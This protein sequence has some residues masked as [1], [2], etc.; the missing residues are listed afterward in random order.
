MPRVYVGTFLTGSEAV[1]L[2][3][4]S[5][6]L[7]QSLDI[8]GT[9]ARATPPEKLHITWQ[10]LGDLEIDKVRAV[11]DLLVNL[12]P[13]IRR[14][15]AP[16]VVIE[17]NKLALWPTADAARVLVVTPDMVRQE[18][19]QTATFVR[20][21]LGPYLNVDKTVERNFKFMPHLTIMRFKEPVNADLPGLSES[22]REIAPV[23]QKIDSIHL[24]ESHVGNNH[25]YESLLA[26]DL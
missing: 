11:K 22:F 19:S 13:E 18:L 4:Y 24:I 15:A 14:L 17:Y 10:F 6:T 7:A 5:L 20:E 3:Q 23:I 26:I 1:R 9:S 25:T 21:A 8:T 12:A 2:S 16:Q